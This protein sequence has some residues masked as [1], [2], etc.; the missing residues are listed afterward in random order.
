M[1]GAHVAISG[2]L[3]RSDPI[4]VL[5]AAHERRVGQFLVQMVR[6]RALA[7][8]LLQETFL[9]AH[10]ARDRLA[11]V[12]SAEAWLFGIARH[13]ALAALRRSRRAQRAV[14]R[15]WQRATDREESA[16]QIELMDALGRA[17]GPDDRALVLLRYVHDIDAPALAQMTGKSPAAIRKRL[18]R[19]CAALEKEMS[20]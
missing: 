2:S 10:R 1:V 5:F 4:E 9:D 11:D 3:E 6:D 19:A 16:S 18:Q 20:P 13:R 7:E 17:L 8:D 15:L 14:E 12:V